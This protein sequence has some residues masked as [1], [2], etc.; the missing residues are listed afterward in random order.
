MEASRCVPVE[1]DLSGLLLFAAGGDSI[2]SVDL[3]DENLAFL[4]FQC[5]MGPIGGS[6][7]GSDRGA[8]P[9][10]LL[11]AFTSLFRSI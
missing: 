6:V 2:F 3:A 9:R 5:L 4:E 7:P 1:Q 11:P 8:V 10:G